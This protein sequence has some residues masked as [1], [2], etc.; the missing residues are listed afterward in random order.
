M[1]KINFIGTFDKT[2]LILNIAKM[3]VNLKQ[4]VLVIDAT[5]REKMKYIIP[6][7]D[8]DAIGYVTNYLEIDIAIGFKNYNEIKRCL[9]MTE[10]SSFMYDYILLDIDD[11]NLITSFDIYNSD[12]NYFVTTFDSY[13]LKKGVEFL[14]EIVQPI[15]ITKLYFSNKMSK[16]DDEYLNFLSLGSKARWTEERIYFPLFTQDQELIME[17]QRLSRIKFKGFSKEYKNALINMVQQLIP[18]EEI[19]NIKRVY[20]QIERGM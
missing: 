16:D 13:C 14:K 11:T 1:T 5:I 17:N 6:K 9:G 12:K 8:T 20:K 10:T 3:L 4:K 2:D 19:Y 15:D 7:I 18:N